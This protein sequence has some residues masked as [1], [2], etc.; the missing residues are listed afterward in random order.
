M[1]HK[2]SLTRYGFKL[3]EPLNKQLDALN[4]ADKAYGSGEVDKKLAALEVYN[5]HR[6][7]KRKRIRR[8]IE[9]NRRTQNAKKKRN[10]KSR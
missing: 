4:K 9:A 1:K 8:L 10:S 6:P 5:K 3:D 7:E 2:G